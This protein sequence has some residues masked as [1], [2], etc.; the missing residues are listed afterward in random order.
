M[1]KSINEYAA[2]RLVSTHMTW[3][4]DAVQVC[5]DRPL[6]DQL[7][8]E[9]CADRKL[10]VKPDQGIKGRGKLGLVG[11]GL[12]RTE[13]LA[14]IHQH[15]RLPLEIRVGETTKTDMLHTF[16][17]EPMKMYA[18]EDELYV[19]ILSNGETDRLLLACAGG[20]DVDVD[21][22]EV[23]D[24]GVCSPDPS[25]SEFDDIIAR[26]GI[27]D[28]Y[29]HTL[30][31]TLS[32]MFIAFRAC[33]FTYMEVNPLVLSETVHLI[34]LA[35]RVDTTA[36]YICQWPDWVQFPTEF[37]QPVMLPSEMAVAQLDAQTGASLKLKILDATAPIWTL[38]AGGGASVVY[39][40]AIVSAHGGGALAN[41]GEYSG[42]P[43]RSQTKAYAHEVV[44]AM[45]ATGNARTLLIGGG[46]ANFTDVT[47]TFHGMI[48]VLEDHADAIREAGI[49]IRVRRG[50]PNYQQALRDMS[51]AGKRL[52]L[53]MSAFGPDT[54]MCHIVSQTSSP[55]PLVCQ[56][57]F[58]DVVPPAAHHTS[59]LVIGV[60]TTEIQRMLDY[61][62]ACRLEK[63]SVVVIVDHLGTQ[64]RRNGT[65]FFG[66][67]EFII[68]IFSSVEQALS[69]VP[70]V[71]CVVNFASYRSAYDTTCD[72]FNYAGD[73]VS[74]IVIVAEGVPERQARILRGL[75]AGTTCRIIGPASVGVLYAG[76]YRLGNIGGTMENVTTSVLYTPGSIGLVT[77][78]GGLANELNHVLSVVS[79][80]IHTGIAIGG[81]RYPCTTFADVLLQYEA[82]P[83][84]KISVML[85]EVG[86]VLEYEVACLIREGRLKKPIVAWCIG[87]CADTLQ[88][89]GLQFG[90]AGARADTVG[91]SA[92]EKNNALRDAGAYV[93]T[94]GFDGIGES[95]HALFVSFVDEGLVKLRPVCVP[96]VLPLDFRVASQQNLVRKTSAI[97]STIV[98]ERGPELLYRGQ[99]LQAIV[100]NNMG[101]GGTIGLLW[102]RRQIPAPFA[103]FIELCLVVCADHG[104]CVSGAHN[105]IVAT[106]A[107]RDMVS[108][109][110]SGILTIGDRF[111]G[112]LDA[113][114]QMLMTA[115]DS[116]TPSELVVDMRSRNTRIPGIG[117]R[118]KSVNNPDSRVDLLTTYMR[119]HCDTRKYLSFFEA[120]ATITTAKKGSLIL[121]VDGAVAACMIDYMSTFMSSV[122][123]RSLVDNGLLNG[124]FI[125]SRSIGL[126]GH[127]LDQLQLGQTLYRHDT[128]DVFY[129]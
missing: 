107:G 103:R 39:S 37:G 105:T 99:S 7:T 5:T 40:D 30:S 9:W 52:G 73:L 58:V 112:A 85:G 71:E 88:Q 126:I 41:Y 82:D 17:V 11:I 29:R 127:H 55:L 61:G 92:L 45:L 43:S 77:R 60:L 84:I 93:P 21:S 34:D 47:A 20:V 35:V 12:S 65:F 129:G 87:T 25:P 62:Y 6:E 68:P 23:L 91:E 64:A 44:Q 28:I 42:A 124:I 63:P 95:V 24:I 89:P 31:C 110:A 72:V 90:H 100:D 51:A 123:I 26:T 108:S 19:C 109:V 104:P 121:N 49:H 78:S 32:E 75:F 83:A 86:G 79:D 111:G 96:R 67:R 48:D 97:V 94:S 114:G 80:G 125:V 50:G 1:A 113:A 33:H 14:W 128:D 120:I 38:I 116:I 76:Q 36:A 4:A 115:V 66:T 15:T 106:R 118:V 56:R 122:D 74:Q 81:D 117:H 70:T 53:Y 46:I 54:P 8:M 57:T 2:K 119:E 16:I 3:C 22:A 27:D 10:V 101:L 18:A 13:C 98:D 102:F 59:I 69:E